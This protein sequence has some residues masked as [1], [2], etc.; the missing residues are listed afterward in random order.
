MTMAMVR[1]KKTFI[2]QASLTIV[3]IFYRTG[4]CLNITKIRNNNTT[5]LNVHFPIGKIYI[6]TGGYFYYWWYLDG[7]KAV[8]TR[9]IVLTRLFTEIMRHY[10]YH[11]STI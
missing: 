1:A 4:H 9:Y 10:A 3:N 5:S 7:I 6:R 11:N 8:L 2:V